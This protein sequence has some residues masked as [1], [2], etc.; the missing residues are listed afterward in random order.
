MQKEKLKNYAL[1]CVPYII[2]MAVIL[3]GISY[4][5]RYRATVVGSDTMI[6][7]QR[8]Y[9]AMAQIKT[10]NFSY[11][12]MNYG[13][14]RTGRV[15]NAIYG[16]FFA[17]LNGLLL[18]ICGTWYRFDIVSIII[19]H[20]VGA[21]SM[22][23]LSLKVK[24]NKWIALLLSLIYTES[25]FVVSFERFNF[26]GWGGALAPLVI[27]QAVNMVQDHKKPIHWFQLALI[28]SILAQIHLW[29]T[30]MLTV[31]IIP[32]AIY[33][34]IKT[35]DRKQMIVAGLKA[36]GAAILLT[37]NI[38]GAMLLLYRNNTL[39]LPNV[40]SLR[41]YALKI[42]YKYNFHAAVLWSIAIIIALQVIYVL[43]HFKKVPLNTLATSV[44]VFWLIIGS[45]LMPWARLQA[46][47]PR[48]GASLQFPY[49]LSVGAWPLLFMAI[50]ITITQLDAKYGLKTKILAFIVLFLLAGQSLAITMKYNRYFTNIY[51]DD[52]K[53]ITNGDYYKMPKDRTQ[54]RKILYKTNSRKLLDLS[55]RAQPD[56]LPAKTSATNDIFEKHVLKNLKHYKYKVKGDRLCLYWHSQ[57]T[58]KRYLPIVMYSQSHLVVNGNDVT[59]V[60][61]NKIY[62]PYVRSKVGNNSAILYFVV[63]TWFWALLWITIFSWI[64]MLLY[65][66]REKFSHQ[67]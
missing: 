8:F 18:L 62:Q 40:H 3:L 26:M 37:A 9:D 4:Q 41:G 16:P 12:Q 32:F 52:S 43:F 7:F 60:A 1:T 11:F 47:Y 14:Y 30:L 55:L 54:F 2:M 15:F 29:S 61:K 34:L 39:A 63:P 21:M 45:R 23:K 28:M 66:L 22:Y 65:S 50:G 36:I 13:L 58:E 31:T 35:I 19:V 27:I 67:R 5:L 44:A 56:Y 25:N 51:L 46:K 64:G 10:G 17:Y 38:W 6:H 59:N 42:A 48:L 53:V 49:R 20:L 24:T 33:G 57:N